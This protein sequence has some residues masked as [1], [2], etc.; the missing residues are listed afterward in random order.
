MADP[1]SPDAME[2]QITEFANEAYQA[3]L[4]QGLSPEEAATRAANEIANIALQ[5]GATLEQIDALR[6]GGITALQ[7]V[8]ANN[9]GIS[10][11]DAFDA[12]ATAMA[13]TIQGFNLSPAI[14]EGFSTEPFSGVTSF[15][16]EPFDAAEFA[17]GYDVGTELTPWSQIALESITAGAGPEGPGEP[18]AGTP[19]G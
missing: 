2:A 14:V 18:P 16:F 8:L 10:M 6:A 5:F 3:A 11:E 15:T 13:D 12:M 9:P 4:A 1:V 17:A 7:S 19:G